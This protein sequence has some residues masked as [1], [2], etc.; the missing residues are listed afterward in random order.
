MENRALLAFAISLA[1]LIGYQYLFPPPE[2]VPAP[3][4]VAAQQAVQPS[5][6]DAVA[7]PPVPAAS[8][9]A[10]AALSAPDPADEK[11]AGVTTSLYDAELTS[12]GGRLRSFLLSE[13]RAGAGR[14]APPLDMVAS[15]SL[16][17]LGVTWVDAAGN[18]ADDR[19]VEYALV[20][21]HARLGDGET[22]SIRLEGRTDDGVEI[23]KTVEFVDGSYLIGL[24]VEVVGNAG[25]VGVQW[26]RAVDP[27][28]GGYYNIEG[29]ALFAD[30]ELEAISAADLEAPESY[31]GAQVS[32]A[33][34]ADHYFLAAFV[35]EAAA[36]LRLVAAAT[37]LLGQATVWN[38]AAA[39]RVRYQVFV[40]P[41]SIHLLDSIGHDLGAAIDLGIFAI[42][43][44][45]LLE[46]L[47]LIE[48]VTH[49]FG[50]AI[51]ALTLLIRLVFY[52]I[53]NKQM[54]AMKAMQRI[55]PE[56]KKVQDRYKDDREK[57]NKE[58]MELYRRHKVNPLSGCLPMVVQIPVFIGLYNV[59]MQA[60]ELRHAPFF[61]WISD[62][63]Q[64]D[65]L[66]SLPIPFVDPPGIPVM[67]LLMGA[68]M[69]LQQK[70][71]P[72]TADPQQ[73]RIMMLMP[74]IFTV[75]FVNFASG[76]VLYWFANNVFQIVQQ[77]L[78]N[79]AAPAPAKA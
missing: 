22:H 70:M 63:S 11:V 71:T 46:V 45:P 49:N 15:E 48:R 77:Y 62:L 12:F 58:M 21:E 18:V 60:I 1:I 52:P 2:P 55:Q 50:W 17:P 59:L 73:Q 78:N 35:P 5:A 29:P 20:E 75:M 3:A 7:P 40:G 79:R 53:N 27:D 28:A 56:V 31:T 33:G 74:L 66:G 39:G 14:D 13:H 57:L 69:F 23:R 16:L 8:A 43:A 9:Q 4:P 30:G 54:E 36:P 61:G 68:S 42:I 25:P 19:A 38:D 34:Y 44:R 76:L 64:P 10:P 47:F 26:V 65:R 32:W 37:P 67:T 51:I 6:G 24:D 41:K 72:T